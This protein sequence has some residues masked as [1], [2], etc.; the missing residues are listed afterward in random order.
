MKRIDDKKFI[1][2]WM[3]SVT[4]DDVAEKLRITKSVINAKAYGLRKRGVKLP[5]LSRQRK[6]PRYTVEELNKVMQSY[7]VPKTSISQ[8]HKNSLFNRKK[9]KI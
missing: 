5:M 2:A 4:Y 8:R 6:E 1:Q 7:T 3:E 9:V